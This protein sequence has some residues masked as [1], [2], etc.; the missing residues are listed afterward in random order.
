MEK[1]T[2][3]GVC[4]NRLNCYQK[5]SEAYASMGAHNP[6]WEAWARKGAFVRNK[7]CYRT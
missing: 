2:V 3:G 7:I 1:G 6:T 5:N 4:I